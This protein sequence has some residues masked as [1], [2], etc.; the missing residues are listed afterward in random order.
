MRRS[1]AEPFSP[2]LPWSARLDLE[3]RA[4]LKPMLNV[5]GFKPGT[6]AT[7]AP[8]IFMHLARDVVGAQG[9]ATIGA[10]VDAPLFK[11]SRPCPPATHVFVPSLSLC[12]WRRG[13]EGDVVIGPLRP[14]NFD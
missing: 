5:A 12:Q 11:L 13:G 6:A 14:P 3:Q 2:P 9:L 10:R 7:I 1:Y 4:F 8:F